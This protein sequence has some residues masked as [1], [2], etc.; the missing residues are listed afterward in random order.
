MPDD[1]HN[2]HNGHN[3]HVYDATEHYDK[4]HDGADHYHDRINCPLTYN[5]NYCPY[6]HY[7]AAKQHN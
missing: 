2:E 5:G 7:D 6:V 3:G 1:E 4:Q